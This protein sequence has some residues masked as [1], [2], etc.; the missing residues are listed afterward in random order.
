M[1]T[2]HERVD[3]P[4]SESVAVETLVLNHYVT[5]SLEDFHL[6]MRRGTAMGTR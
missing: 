4:K 3:G 5:K 2:R 1:T 6:K